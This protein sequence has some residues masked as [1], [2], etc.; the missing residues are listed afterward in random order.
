MSQLVQFEL[1][2]GAGEIWV[3]V[4]EPAIIPGGLQPAERDGEGIVV[5]AKNTFEE[6]LA[7]FR[8]AAQAIIRTFS[9]LA[10]DE[11]EITLG[12]KFSVDARAI[13]AATGTEAT[14]GVKVVWKA[15][16]DVKEKK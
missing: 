1:E 9:D 5:R 14:I 12:I 8:P 3:E 16:S 4:T 15:D 10:P 13:I 7:T 11:L 2:Q 6:A